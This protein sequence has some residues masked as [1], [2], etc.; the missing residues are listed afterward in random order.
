MA[1]EVS[2]AQ[3]SAED[4]RVLA[5]TDEVEIE[6][7]RAS[8]SS[9][10]TIIWVM[11]DG[12]R[13]YIRSVRGAAGR[14]YQVVTSGSDA[15]LHAGPRTWTIRAVPVA[16][17]AEVA[18]VSEAIRRKYHARWPGPTAAMLRP[19]VLPTTLRVEPV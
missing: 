7:P 1:E 15:R 14:W 19:D 12:E 13:V 8:G 11:V 3:F 5:E 17:R 4:L 16:D 6:T 18:R 10:R 9:R 2:M